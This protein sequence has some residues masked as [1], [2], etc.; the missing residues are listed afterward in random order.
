MKKKI[1]ILLLSLMCLKM[2]AQITTYYQGT[3]LQT[4]LQYGKLNSVS[5]LDYIYSKAKNP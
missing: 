3:T 4:F 1:T 2:S 5:D